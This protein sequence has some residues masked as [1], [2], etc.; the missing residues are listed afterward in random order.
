MY[1]CPATLAG[2]VEERVSERRPDGKE[3]FLPGTSGR[4]RRGPGF[5]EI[6]TETGLSAADVDGAQCS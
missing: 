4:P 2:S 6:G 5:A 1:R 3:Q